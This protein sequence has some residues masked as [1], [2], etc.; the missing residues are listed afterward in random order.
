MEI[1]CVLCHSFSF[2]GLKSELLE[3]EAFWEFSKIL[4][5]SS[6]FSK[7]VKTR[8]VSA[9]LTSHAGVCT[10][11]FCGPFPLEPNSPNNTAAGRAFITARPFTD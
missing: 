3:M 11:N 8:R 10:Q 9:R 7:K 5:F 6:E 1:K 4:H 2:S